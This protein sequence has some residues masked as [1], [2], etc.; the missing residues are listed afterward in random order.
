MI[1]R[2]QCPSDDR[3]NID[4]MKRPKLEK[5]LEAKG[6]HPNP[7]MSNKVMKETLNAMNNNG[8]TDSEYNTVEQLIQP[9][10]I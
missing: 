5:L 4:T 6:V 10:P 1:L 3:T 9:K 2:R 7:G 8:P